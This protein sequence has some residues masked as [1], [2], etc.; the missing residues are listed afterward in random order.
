[1]KTEV[2]KFRVKGEDILKKEAT[3][4]H[5]INDF[6]Y[7][8]NELH[9]PSFAQKHKTPE[10]QKYSGAKSQRHNDTIAQKSKSGA[11]RMQLSGF[12]SRLERILPTGSSRWCIQESCP[13]KR[14]SQRSVIEQ[15]LEE[16]FDRQE[17]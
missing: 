11:P 17:S 3:R 14:A 6:L 8:Q 12:M 10:P 1:M 7:D 16:F 5:S 9:S 15:A 4:P 13:R 2:N